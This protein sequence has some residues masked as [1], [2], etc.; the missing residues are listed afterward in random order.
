MGFPLSISILFEKWVLAARLLPA[1]TDFEQLVDN[2]SVTAWL[3]Y[4]L[5]LVIVFKERMSRKNDK[6]KG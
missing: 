2:F 5:A 6:L 1:G 4:G 3:Y